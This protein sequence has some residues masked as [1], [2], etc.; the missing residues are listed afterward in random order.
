MVQWSRAYGGEPPAT[1]SSAAAAPQRGARLLAQIHDELL[2]ECDERGAGEAA[3]AVR[4][5]M[6][7]A[8]KLV[9][10]LKVRRSGRAAWR[11]GSWREESTLQS[12]FS[13]PSKGENSGREKLGRDAGLRGQRLRDA[14]ERHMHIGAGL[15][16]TEISKSERV[17]MYLHTLE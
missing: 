11:A 12:F 10:P 17:S 6:E 14:G 5:V 13:P 1:G 8:W 16:V 15:R 2:F 3:A 4:R 9:V 7:G